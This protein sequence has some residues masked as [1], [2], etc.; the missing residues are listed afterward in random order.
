[1]TGQQGAPAELGGQALRLRERRFISSRND[2]AQPAG[3][4]GL[5]QSEAAFGRK[6]TAG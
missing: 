4:P 6:S 5:G 1:M 2:G 3:C